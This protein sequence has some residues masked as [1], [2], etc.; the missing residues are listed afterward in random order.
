[1]GERGPFWQYVPVFGVF[2]SLGCVPLLGLC[3]HFWGVPLVAVCSPSWFALPL[4][5]CVP[6]FGL[7]PPFWA[8]F[9]F[10]GCVP[11]FGLCSPFWAT[12]PIWAPQVHPEAVLPPPPGAPGRSVAVQPLS[13]SPGWRRSPIP[14]SHPPPSARGQRVCEQS[15]PSGAPLPGH[16]V[17][18]AL[19]PQTEGVR[20]SVNVLS[21]RKDLPVLF[22]VRQK[23]AV[24]SFQVPLILRG[25]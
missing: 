13:P 9:L 14:A 1:M 21:D 15:P 11:V 16:S 6:P 8:V 10:L 23:E 18:S 12:F 19:S 2:P 24:V 25:L 22:V 7:H 3:S 4:L 20:V 5:G 17:A